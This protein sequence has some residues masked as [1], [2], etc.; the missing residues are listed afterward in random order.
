MIYYLTAVHLSLVCCVLMVVSEER[1][2]G[3]DSS[4]LNM[5]KIFTVS[6]SG[7]ENIFLDW[8]MIVQMILSILEVMQP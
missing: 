4:F 1:Y 6:T 3:S 8:L 5:P 2:H 7:R